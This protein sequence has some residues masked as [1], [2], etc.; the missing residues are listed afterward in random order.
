MRIPPGTLCPV[1]A[2]RPCRTTAT[3]A[4]AVASRITNLRGRPITCSY[5]GSEAWRSWHGVPDRM[6]VAS[7]VGEGFADGD[8][9]GAGCRR[10]GGEGGA[11]DDEDEPDTDGEHGE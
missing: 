8:A 6:V 10:V 2:P 5:D 1:A 9:G 11:E 7:E 4:A 3:A